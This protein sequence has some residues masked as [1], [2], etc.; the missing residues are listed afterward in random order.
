MRADER[1]P[2]S[3]ARELHL[4][5]W[6]RFQLSDL[7]VYHDLEHSVVRMKFWIPRSCGW[8]VFKPMTSTRRSNSELT[9]SYHLPVAGQSRPVIVIGQWG[10]CPAWMCQS[11]SEN[12][13]VDVRNEPS[14]KQIWNGVGKVYGAYTIL[15]VSTTR[16]TRKILVK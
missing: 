10:K 4:Y 11:I 6:N 9:C 14:D 15:K 2:T 5:Y 16:H 13:E 8:A 1:C 12:N 3:P 7:A